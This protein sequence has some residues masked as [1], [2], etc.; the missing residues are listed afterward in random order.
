[1][2]GATNTILTD[3]PV[4]GVPGSNPTIGHLAVNPAS[5]RLYVGENGNNIM[6]VFDT[7]TNAF[8]HQ[9]ALPA[10]YAAPD[11]NIDTALNRIYVTG[12]YTANVAILDGA[13]ESM[14]AL[15]PIGIAPVS[16]GVDS[17]RHRAY[18]VNNSPETVSV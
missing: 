8:L 4:P 14:V 11:I 9:V 1:I 16:V 12:R 2:D 7:D 18:V 3:L 15:L 6:E 17:A 5:H 10:G 13:S